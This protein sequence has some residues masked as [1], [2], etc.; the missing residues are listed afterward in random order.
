[1]PNPGS[2]LL[3][4]AVPN[5]VEISNAT[6]G[7]ESNEPTPRN[8]GSTKNDRNE[9]IIPGYGSIGSVASENLPGFTD[10]DIINS[11][12]LPSLQSG[13]HVL[14]TVSTT[15]VLVVDNLWDS[16]RTSTKTTGP[17]NQN[18]VGLTANAAES[19][20]HNLGV[21]GQPPKSV[22]S[23]GN[24]V[25]EL[26][27]PGS[28][29]LNVK[30]DNSDH[31]AISKTSSNTSAVK[32]GI[33][34][35]ARIRALSQQKLI[36]DNSGGTVGTAGTVGTD[37]RGPG[38]ESGSVEAGDAKGHVAPEL[39]LTKSISHGLRKKI[40]TASSNCST[41]QVENILAAR[42]APLSKEELEEDAKEERRLQRC[43][44]KAAL[45]DNTVKPAYYQS[46][47]RFDKEARKKEAKDREKEERFE[48]L[49]REVSDEAAAKT[50]V[51]GE[52]KM[53]LQN[54][55]TGNLNKTMHHK[56]TG[57][58][59]LDNDETAHI[60]QS[61]ALGLVMKE[62][63]KMDTPTQKAE[64][65]KE[66]VRAAS[67]FSEKL[68]RVGSGATQ[69]E[70]TPRSNGYAQNQNSIMTGVTSLTGGMSLAGAAANGGVNAN[71]VYTSQNVSQF[72]NAD[73]SN[74]ANG[75][76]GGGLSKSVSEGTRNCNSVNTG[77]SNT[78]ADNGGMGAINKAYAPNHQNFFS[79]NKEQGPGRL[80]VG[81][82]E[83]NGPATLTQYERQNNVNGTIK[84]FSFRQEP[85]GTGCSTKHQSSLQ[86]QGQ[87]QTQYVPNI[88][89][90]PYHLQAN[91]NQDNNYVGGQL[92]LATMT[93]HNRGNGNHNQIQNQNN[94]IFGPRSNMS[95][96]NHSRR[97]SVSR[98]RGYTNQGAGCETPN[99]YEDATIPPSRESQYPNAG[100]CDTITPA[101]LDMA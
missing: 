53:S 82:Q 16:I 43:A 62:V 71:Q 91:G 87:S 12:N 55:N 66:F 68:R 11:I 10:D 1:M 20:N 25:P 18:S 48:N 38:L 2:T 90:D 83:A 14:P 52:T 35:H 86:D 19:P 88:Y 58:G 59:E 4:P 37:K 46:E 89:V 47:H 42:G 45:K 93:Q 61:V 32:H 54:Q 99:P 92:N 85:T 81:R 40:S 72:G 69:N 101:N 31:S 49:R 65:K 77:N 57:S 33:N 67:E 70:N 27:G 63:E 100:Q 23:P 21:M 60:V 9:S 7:L 56:G 5:S 78:V 24:P 74:T 15:P 98:P 64:L 96:T 80:V 73:Q 36:R 94:G 3:E 41:S 29:G 76:L 95:S 34:Y 17:A 30:R 28:N 50:E 13:P 8:N 22:T 44:D 6:I 84:D 51:V 39:R 97:S 26:G 75:G 79:M